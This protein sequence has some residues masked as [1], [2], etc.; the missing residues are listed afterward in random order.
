MGYSSIEQVIVLCALSNLTSVSS[1]L[2]PVIATSEIMP[3]LARL[4]KHRCI[5]IR[6]GAIEVMS[7]LAANPA[8]R[9]RVRSA[10]KW[11]ELS[12][13]LEEAQRRG[14][15]STFTFAAK[16]LRCNAG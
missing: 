6:C 10:V 5:T 11:P 3:S 2:H 9:Q 8:H 16:L 12:L 7:Q 13:F 15:D 4:L 14:I 1:A